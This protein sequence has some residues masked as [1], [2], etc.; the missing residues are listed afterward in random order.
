MFKKLFGK[1]ASKAPKGFNLLKISAIDRLTND[2]VKVTFA[3]DDQLR[4]SYNFIPGQYVNVIVEINGKELRRSYSI[5]SGTNES[6]AIAI[7]EVE[8][9]Q[10]STWFNKT[11]T[12]GIE[13][14]VGTPEGN[15]K[16]SS[17]HK[18]I[19]G[20]AAGSGITPM[21]SIAKSMASQGTMK[22]FYGSRTSDSIIFKDEIAQITNLET[23]H[24]LSGEN[25]DGFES[26]RI[27][28][29]KF[30]EIV[31]AN[32]DLLKSD[33]FFLCGP[34]QLIVD[35]KEVLE[36][37]GVADSKIHYELFTTPVLMASESQEQSTESFSGKSKIKIILDDEEV[38]FELGADDKN[39]L[40]SAIDEGLDAPYSCRG[41][42]C[43]SCKAKVLEGNCTMKL[44][45]ALTDDEVADGYILT[46][47]A[48][49]NSENVTVSFDE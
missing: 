11:A 1:S 16:L 39:I 17:D 15:F 47:Q 41:G 14:P 38:E 32:L 24:F 20:I 40:D 35:M 7:K 23:T 37:F 34:E 29:S 4:S 25:K 45:Y 43:C 21:M 26:G 9:G 31:K 3:I 5:C 8:S 46:C 30:T 18:N 12:A 49:P 33:A 2:A 19:V 6:L 48:H 28:K 36:M 42:V 44:N 22:L 13:I 10:V 27:D